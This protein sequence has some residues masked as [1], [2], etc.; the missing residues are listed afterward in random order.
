MGDAMSFIVNRAELARAVTVCGSMVAAAKNKDAAKRAL[1]EFDGFNLGVAVCDRAEVW[2]QFGLHDPIYNE[3]TFKGKTV[4]PTKPLADFL[5]AAQYETV[6]LG[7]DE[8][9]TLTATSG[10][11][12]TRI[13]GDSPLNY[14]RPWER[15]NLEGD[16]DAVFFEVAAP[17]LREAIGKTANTTLDGHETYNLN[18]VLLSPD[19]RPNRLAL[20]SC[21]GERFNRAS[22]RVDPLAWEAARDWPKQ[23]IV[24][25]KGLRELGKFCERLK[26]VRLA[27]EGSWLLATAEG[28]AMGAAL[29]DGTFP[30]DLMF[31]PDAT[32]DYAAVSRKDLLDSLRRVSIVAD[33]GARWGRFAFAGDRLTLEIANPGVG[34]SE[35][36]VASRHTKEFE[37]ALDPAALAEILSAM[38][39]EEVTVGFKA[40]GRVY[41]ISSE[42]DESYQALVSVPG[43]S[44]IWR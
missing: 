23:A 2:C 14:P 37:T 19:T 35:D 13:Y 16:K 15:L 31:P 29:L 34:K 7:L 28:A 24:S 39:G 10:R 18:G 30:D 20:S 11:Y 42:G 4:V 32:M 26:A 21:D 8:N 6:A 41:R 27:M 5:K 17:A 25:A 12:S 38:K 36:W 43:E 33:K 22:F 1:L 44:A 9:G 3:K 40:D